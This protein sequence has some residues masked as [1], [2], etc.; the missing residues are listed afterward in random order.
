[1]SIFHRNDKIAVYMEDSKYSSRF[2]RF[3]GFIEDKFSILAV[4]LS[5]TKSYSSM[6]AKMKIFIENLAKEIDAFLV[7][8]GFRVEWLIFIQREKKSRRF[9]GLKQEN[10]RIPYYEKAFSKYLKGMKGKKQMIERKQYLLEIKEDKFLNEVNFVTKLAMKN[11]LML[12]KGFED[13]FLFLMGKYPE[14]PP[15][16]INES[17][18]TK[19]EIN[20][21]LESIRDIAKE[22]HGFL[23]ALGFGDMWVKEIWKEID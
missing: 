5:R 2:R 23:Q 16:T 9:L 15:E 22:T 11:I 3:N 1:M 4:N 6:E 17:H 13:N 14:A 10:K 20:R 18:L 8:L 19:N 21:L 12:L 7:S